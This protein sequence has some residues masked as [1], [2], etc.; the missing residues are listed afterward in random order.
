MVL[1][2]LLEVDIHEP[3]VRSERP[4]EVPLIGLPSGDVK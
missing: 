1:Q 3:A 2:L 4:L